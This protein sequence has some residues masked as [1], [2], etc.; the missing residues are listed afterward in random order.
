VTVLLT[1]FS[2][3]DSLSPNF[4]RRNS[5]NN[6]RDRSSSDGALGLM[7][8]KFR[9][10]RKGINENWRHP[11]DEKKE[12]GNSRTINNVE[13]RQDSTRFT[14]K[15]SGENNQSNLKRNSYSGTNNRNSGKRNS[16][17]EEK[18][19]NSEAEKGAKRSGNEG[20]YI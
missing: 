1:G 14:E 7:R 9:P 19:N 5:Q 16:K 11:V 12:A 13:T 17:H 4:E 18:K 10:E 3:L 8:K 6:Q 15:H 20:N 2:N